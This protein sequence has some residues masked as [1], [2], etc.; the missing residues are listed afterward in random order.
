MS[1]KVFYGLLWR[2]VLAMV[3][4]QGLI[5]LIKYITETLR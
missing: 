3:L 1:D 2:V 4:A 5:G